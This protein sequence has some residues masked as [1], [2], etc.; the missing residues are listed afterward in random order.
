MFDIVICV[1]SNYVLYALQNWDCKVIRDIV[2]DVKYLI[3]GM[4]SRGI[5]V[6]FCWVPSHC[7][8]WNEISDKLAKHGATKNMSAISRNALLLSHQYLKGYV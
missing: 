3:H 4:I 2:Y 1:D 8:Y 7:L 6:E 5:V